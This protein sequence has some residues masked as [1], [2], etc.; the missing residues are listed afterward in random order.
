MAAPRVPSPNAAA[1]EPATDTTTPPGT[2]TVLMRLLFWSATMTLV[3][4]ASTAM[5]YGVR[6]VA[7]PAVPSPEVGVGMGN[8]VDAVEP[9]S[10]TGALVTGL[11]EKLNQKRMDVAMHA[12]GEVR[13]R[14]CVCVC[15]VVCVFPSSSLLLLLLPRV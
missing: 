8:A 15:F 9:A 6:N 2:D 10:S 14:A 7:A 5:P 12:D 1:P 4:A 11:T 3:P 13:V